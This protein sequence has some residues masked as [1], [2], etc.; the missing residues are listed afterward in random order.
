MT[1]RHDLIASW[2]QISETDS[3]A[4]VLTGRYRGHVSCAVPA[5]RY[6]LGLEQQLASP[7]RRVS[8]TADR[9]AVVCQ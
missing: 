1:Y 4:N 5:A 6:E 2:P 3:L 8:R 9:A 7:F